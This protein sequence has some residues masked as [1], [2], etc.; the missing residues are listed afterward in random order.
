MEVKVGLTHLFELFNR[1]W[2]GKKLRDV[3]VGLTVQQIAI[4]AIRAEILL[5]P[6]N[7]GLE[8]IDSLVKIVLN[9]SLVNIN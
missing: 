5:R 4:L 3:L 2:F 7:V 1:V 9:K 6:D 8:E